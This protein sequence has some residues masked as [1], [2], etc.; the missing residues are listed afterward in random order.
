M[1][2][3]EYNFCTQLLKDF[4][5]VIEV[6]IIIIFMFTSFYLFDKGYNMDD[7]NIEKEVIEISVK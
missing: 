1:D 4:L 6:I 5:D 3:N 2:S 7:Q